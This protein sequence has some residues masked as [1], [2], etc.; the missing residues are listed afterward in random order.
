MRSFIKAL[1]LACL[2]LSIAACS[3]KY[4]EG[5]GGSGDGS[6]AGGSGDGASGS[7]CETNGLITPTLDT[8]KAAN[9]TLALDPAFSTVRAA[10][11]EHATSVEA[12]VAFDDVKSLVAGFALTKAGTSDPGTQDQHDE[13]AMGKLSGVT[14]VGTFT[15][16]PF[17]TY[18]GFP[19]VV[20]Q[21]R[22]QLATAGSPGALRDKLLGALVGK[23]LKIA[24]GS[25][26]SAQTTSFT[27]VLTTVVR[28]DRVVLIGGVAPEAAFANR[29]EQTSIRLRDLTNAT[30]LARGLK[31]LKAECDHS[32]V[33]ALPRA[34]IVWLI[35]NSVSMSDDQQLIA[36]SSAE[37]FK[38]LAG[39][40]IDFRIGV[41]QA[42]C[43]TSYLGLTER[44]FTRD[45][46]K[47]SK[48]IK[49]PDGPAGC[50]GEAP[51]T[52]GKHLHERILSKH[53]VTDANDM[54]SG[55]R[56]KA[57]L[58]YVFVTD[59]DER[60]LQS[61]DKGSRSITQAKM[62]AQPSFKSLRDYYRRAGIIA[63]GMIALAPRCIRE[64]EPSWAAKAIV[65]ATGGASWP[66][67][68]TNKPVLSSALNAMV[69]AAQGV[70]STFKLSRVPISSTLKLTLGGKTVKRSASDGFDYD[71]PNNAIIFNTG[72]SAA[73]P[74]KGDTIYVSY[75]FFED[76]KR[77][78]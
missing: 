65:E 64:Y 71:G 56:S 17:L 39:S 29:A 45:K 77:I 16:Q 43:N 76:A 51:I 62:V 19:A 73:R 6:G 33:S 12:A 69:K 68:A 49:E 37:F 15:R 55:L 53:E 52:A 70:T 41:M 35:D 47:F 66:I 67:C 18:D 11:I 63:F 3:H 27:L 20:S 7:A 24:G 4:H 13:Q 58:M 9:W 42:G 78:K 31:T 22:V 14:V 25:S 30:A 61:D 72:S 32:Q 46:K 23:S 57:K 59:E 1:L 34:D 74:K 38:R 10:Q 54:S 21:R 75:R 5:N 50:E 28:P 26:F 8:R 48:W 40:N 60:P 2:S 44:K 36:D